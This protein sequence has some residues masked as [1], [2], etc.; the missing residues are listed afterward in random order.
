MDGGL[1]YLQSFNPTASSTELLEKTL[2]GRKKT[3]NWLEKLVIE[4]ATSGNKI[5]R[6][7]IGPGGSGKTHRLRGLYDRI[8]KRKELKEKLKIAYLNENEYGIAS[9]LDFII[10]LLRAFMKWD[11]GNSNYLDAE[12]EKLKKTPPYDQETL[13]VN[14]LKKHIEG[15]TL[16]LIA[17]NIGDIFAGLKDSGQRRLRDLMQQHPFFT[18]IASNKSLFDDIRDPNKPFYLFFALTHLDEL[19]LD[20][21]VL[22]LKSIAQWEN[23]T[24][25]L[26]FIDES[27]GRGRIHA[28]FDITGGN[29]R[30]LV[31]V[32][33]YLKIDYKNNLSYSFIK[34]V[35]DLIPYYQGFINMLSAQQ[36]KIIQYLCQTRRPSNVKEIAENCFNSQNTISKQMSTLV[37]YKYVDAA[38]A[39]KET[40]YELSDPLFR[41]CLEVKDY[42]AA[43][44]RRFIDFLGNLY[45]AEEI[46]E[47]YINS[48]KLPEPSEAMFVRDSNPGYNVEETTG[49]ELDLNGVLPENLDAYLEKT[50][51]KALPQAIF[52]TLIQHETIETKRFEF[53]ESILNE[54][55]NEN[56]SMI[57]PLKFLDIGIR[58]LKKKE[59]NVLFQFTKE[60]RNTFKKFVLD[61]IKP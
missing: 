19:T 30:L 45:S 34:A 51:V 15:K 54:T 23:K 7:V 26:E 27:E 49:K 2:V 28:V 56:E 36:R 42:G 53:I 12:I 11:P 6:L 13:A 29:H 14:I 24:D 4:S 17:E 38:S 3:V 57:I 18:I 8:S 20:E 9:F 59:K 21:T 40:F 33:N 44:V 52:N 37:K 35:N 5:Q 50:T 25:F 58:H 31:T 41:I 39:G 22:F 32:Y 55:F 48:Y 10:R 1:S 16:L 61:K 60:E 47:K 43:Q 46:K